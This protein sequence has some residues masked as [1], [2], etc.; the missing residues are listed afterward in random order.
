MILRTPLSVNRSRHFANPYH[1][2]MIRIR[3]ANAMP[4]DTTE[5]NRFVEIKLSF[6]SQHNELNCYES[7]LQI[8]KT[9]WSTTACCTLRCEVF[10]GIDKLVAFEVVL[11]IVKLPVAT[12]GCQ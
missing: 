2:G 6:R 11:F 12:I 5:T 3:R 9:R 10:S 7:D 1:F 4:E 8:G